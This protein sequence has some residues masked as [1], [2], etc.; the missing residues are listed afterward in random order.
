MHTDG[1]QMPHTTFI[2]LAALNFNTICLPWLCTPAFFLPFKLPLFCFS[3]LISIDLI[4]WQQSLNSY[5]RKQK[6]RCQKPEIIIKMLKMLSRSESICEKQKE[7]RFNV[8]GLFLFSQMLNHMLN[9]SKIFCFSVLL[10]Y[11]FLSPF[12]CNHLLV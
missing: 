7:N 10:Y 6:C 1:S 3:P 11:P 9:I 12:S 5:G 4:L 8:S 2:R